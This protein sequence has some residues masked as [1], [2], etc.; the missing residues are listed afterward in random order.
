MSEKT[1]KDRVREA[2]S[3]RRLAFF[4][5]SLATMAIFTAIVAI[6]MLY[7]Y[8]QYIQSSLETEI[9]FC[10]HRSHG[11]WDE[12]DKV[13]YAL[14][15]ETRIKRAAYIAGITQHRTSRAYP[16]Q[17]ASG[18]RRQSYATNVRSQ[19]PPPRRG[20]GAQRHAYSQG[21]L[22][23]SVGVQHPPFP[24]PAGDCCSCG[25]GAAG[26]PGMDGAPGK[27]GI[28]G[29]DAKPF[30][31][32]T[33]ADFCFDCPPAPQG[34]PGRPGRKGPPG[35]PG[36]PG[37]TRYGGPVNGLPGP[38]GPRGPAGRPGPAGPRGPPGPPGKI[39]PGAAVSRGPPGP[40]G[41]RGPPGPN[42]LTGLAGKTMHGPP[43]PMG[44]KGL[45]GPPGRPGP[46]GPPGAP[47]LRGSRGDCDHC[48]PPRTAPGYKL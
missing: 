48:P 13:H 25:V 6:P 10:K 3:L 30:E 29:R 42:G 20:D 33:P 5:I 15:V 41:P 11:L 24:F 43:G 1:S 7:S 32:R 19:L 14:G 22:R 12:F 31:Q 23:P 46:M 37:P 35:R 36:P 26:P 28:P 34:P 27:D 2:E 9:D 17:R 47:G 40:P 38:P 39:L 45:D 16:R 4:G 18:V 8:L 44:D 21:Y